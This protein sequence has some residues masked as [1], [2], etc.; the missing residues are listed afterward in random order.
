MFVYLSNVACKNYTTTVIEPSKYCN[1]IFRNLYCIN[2]EIKKEKKVRPPWMF[3]LSIL[4]KSQEND[5]ASISF[6]TDRRTDV[7]FEL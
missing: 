2:A 3:Q 5:V 4:N 6:L 7:H 1:L